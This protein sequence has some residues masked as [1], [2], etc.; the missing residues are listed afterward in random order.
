MK[1]QLAPLDI[2]VI[3]LVLFVGLFFLAFMPD[4]FIVRNLAVSTKITYTSNE[5]DLTLLA[6]LPLKYEGKTF[7]WIFSTSPSS[8]QNQ[9]FKESFTKALNKTLAYKLK[10]YKLRIGK[11]EL[12]SGSCTSYDYRAA[13]PIFKPYNPTDLVGRI[14]LSYQKV[15]K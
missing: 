8:I 5:A 1:A 10:C 2:A 9:N 6:L 13:Y 3:A 4:K 7:Y 14:E 11:Y 15:S 12:K